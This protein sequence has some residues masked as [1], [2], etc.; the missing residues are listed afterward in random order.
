MAAV[1]K[2]IVLARG[3]AAS[4]GERTVWRDADFEINRGEFVAVLGPN[5]AGKTT[6]F[7]LILGLMPPA[8]GSL[9]IFGHSP[10]RGDARIGYV[11]QRHQ[12][13]SD[14]RLES[15]E[16]VKLGLSGSRWG[17]G[18][19]SEATNQTSL[20][21]LAEVGAENLAHRSLGSLSGGELQ[22]IFLAQALVGDPQLLLLDEPLANLDF[23]RQSA[24]LG[25]I[26]QVAKSRKVAVL[27]IAHDINPLLPVMDEVIYM[28]N[29]QV[30]TG[31]PDKV[32]TTEILSRLYNAPVEVIKDSRGRMA[33]L[34]A[35]EAAHPHE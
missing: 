1:S 7:K 10:R 20:G 17:F 14:I 6:L 4:Y 16:L 28:A 13:D 30:A 18:L 29:G 12:I 24:L 26:S 31:K 35:E 5:G 27:L 19:N 33:V 3:L 15:L 9:R 34:G 32:V 22:R 11:P 25:L 21:V 23:R 2:A 8:A